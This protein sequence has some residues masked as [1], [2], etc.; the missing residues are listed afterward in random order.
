MVD[1]YTQ[2]SEKMVAGLAGKLLGATAKALPA[3]F[4]ESVKEKAPDWVKKQAAEMK[5]LIENISGKGNAKLKAKLLT[6]LNTLV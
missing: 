3:P 6:H 4:S 1:H 2:F 5:K